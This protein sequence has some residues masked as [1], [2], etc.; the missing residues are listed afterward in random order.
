MKLSEAK[1]EFI[2]RWGTLGSAWN[3]S[4]AMGEIYGFLLIT[5]SPVSTDE[6][7]AALKLS[8][9]TVNSN[10]RE[11]MDWGLVIKKRVP[12]DRREYFVAEKDFWKVAA[13]VMA[14]RRRKE[15]DPLIKL[16][17]EL[18]VEGKDSETKAFTD[19]IKQIRTV[20]EQADKTAEIGIKL[21]IFALLRK[22]FK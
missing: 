7:M 2:S 11:L 22:I 1:R 5:D 10:M 21:G 17:Y 14:E 3:V 12:G 15:L 9:G 19:L 13:L 18:S 6:V 16:T 8:R 20:A 4:R